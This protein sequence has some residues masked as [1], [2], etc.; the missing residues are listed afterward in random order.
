MRYQNFDV[1]DIDCMK[2]LKWV[3]CDDG[4]GGWWWG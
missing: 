2:K 4:G 3:L 1:G